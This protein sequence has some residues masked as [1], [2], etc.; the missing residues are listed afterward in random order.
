MHVV[1][2][3]LID[4]TLRP[5]IVG[6]TANTPQVKQAWRTAKAIKEIYDCPIVLGG[7]HVSVLP[8]ES[9]EKPYVD[10]VVRGEG[11]DG[12]HCV[13]QTKADPWTGCRIP[14]SRSAPTPLPATP[15][16]VRHSRRS[17]A[18]IVW[19]HDARSFG[20]KSSPWVNQLWILGRRAHP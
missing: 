15:S 11:E 10:V 17:G 3:D 8:E 13:G 19:T 2:V 12:G 6:I 14:I 7:P 1:A 20:S 5:H 16:R 18:W 9:C 4:R